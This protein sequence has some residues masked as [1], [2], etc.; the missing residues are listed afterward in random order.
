MNNLAKTILLKTY[1]T[2]F[3]FIL[4]LS[5]QAVTFAQVSPVQSAPKY[6]IGEIEVTGNTSFSSQTVITYSGLRKGE[7]VS[8]PGDKISA[9]IKKL[10]SSNLFSSIN[11]YVSKIEG[12]V[13]DL[14]IELID[15]PELKE[16]KIEGVKK[17]KIPEIIKENK[18]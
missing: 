14:E 10:W 4:L 17:K 11:V 6:T 2:R 1:F 13:A 12:N 5:F 18:N 8:I 15:L 9:A 3:I 16:A 7:E